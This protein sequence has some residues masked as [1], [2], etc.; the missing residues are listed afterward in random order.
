M[1]DKTSKVKGFKFGIW[2]CREKNSVYTNDVCY[3]H[4]LTKNWRVSTSFI[5]NCWNELVI[6]S[7]FSLNCNSQFFITRWKNFVRIF[8][9]ETFHVETVYLEIQL[10]ILKFCIRK[11]VCNCIMTAPK[12]NLNIITIPECLSPIILKTSLPFSS[13]CSTL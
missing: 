1:F 3:Y 9:G 8:D 12:D 13:E 7:K 6:P 5:L 4:I 2:L 10:I 11:I